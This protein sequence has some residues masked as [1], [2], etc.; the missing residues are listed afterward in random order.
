M[1]RHLLKI[2]FLILLIFIGLKFSFC[3]KDIVIKAFPDKFAGIGIEI[4]KDGDYANIVRVFHSSPAEEAGIR[5]DDILIAVDNLNISRLSL[6]ELIDK[7]RGQPGTTVILT[8]K[9]SKDKSINVISV[10]RK[11]SILT[12]KG[13]IFEK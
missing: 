10:T 1:N 7:L 6:P 8:I 13:Y 4:E 3:E 2:L 11:R 12:D 5:P 9:S